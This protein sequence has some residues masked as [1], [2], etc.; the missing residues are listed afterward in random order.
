MT[1]EHAPPPNE[2]GAATNIIILDACRDNPFKAVNRGIERGLARVHAVITDPPEVRRILLHLIK[3]GV[4]LPGLEAS[5]L[6]VTYFPLPFRQSGR[7]LYT[8]SHC[9]LNMTNQGSLLGL[10]Q[11]NLSLSLDDDGDHGDS[12]PSKGWMLRLQLRAPQEVPQVETTD[13]LEIPALDTVEGDEARWRA[14]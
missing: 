6:P 14:I 8:V 13:P 1:S 9:F 11:N 2:S 10:Y 12:L 5:E 3:T 4:A 7:G